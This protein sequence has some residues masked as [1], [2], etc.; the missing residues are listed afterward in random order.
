LKFNFSCIGH[1]QMVSWNQSD[2]RSIKYC[3]WIRIWL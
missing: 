1:E 2:W 3:Y